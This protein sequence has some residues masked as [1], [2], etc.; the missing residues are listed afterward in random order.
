MSALTGSILAPP[1][2][3]SARRGLLGRL[4]SRAIDRLAQFHARRGSGCQVLRIGIA[5]LFR[6]VLKA[7]LRLH[8]TG[9]QNLPAT[10]PFVLVSNHASHLDAPCLLA[11]LPLSRAKMASAAAASDYFFASLPGAAAAALLTNALPFD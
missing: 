3:A 10:G 2:R 6:I 5:L 7:L 1:G 11:S 4:R 9:R 8:V